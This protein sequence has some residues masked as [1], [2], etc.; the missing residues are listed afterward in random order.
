M[1]S[2]L[3]EQMQQL[4][5]WWNTCLLRTIAGWNKYRA[6]RQ[7]YTEYVLHLAKTTLAR[8]IITERINPDRIILTLLL[9]K[10]SDRK[11]AIKS[12]DKN[13]STKRSYYPLSYGKCVSKEQGYCRAVGIKIITCNGDPRWDD[14]RADYS[15][16]RR[17]QKPHLQA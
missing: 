5:N 1:C 9:G 17:K 4:T 11:A 15:C 12:G 13:N 6:C 10:D 8:P 3:P 14:R 16:R 2:V 7:W